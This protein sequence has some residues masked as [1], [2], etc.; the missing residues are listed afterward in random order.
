MNATLEPSERERSLREKSSVE[1]NSQEVAD[2]VEASAP[3]SF[4][5][6]FARVDQH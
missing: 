2:A 6:S 5:S 1:S 4:I 3:F